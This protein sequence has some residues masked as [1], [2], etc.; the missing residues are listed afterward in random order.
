MVQV[1]EKALWVVL[2]IVAIV[3]SVLILNYRFFAFHLPS[4]E[5]PAFDGYIKNASW[6]TEFATETPYK[7]GDVLEYMFVFS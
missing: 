6:N 5:S 3:V 2:A 1:R 7:K 4:S